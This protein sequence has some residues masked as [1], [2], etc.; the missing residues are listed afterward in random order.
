M[1]RMKWFMV[2]E[3]GVVGMLTT[4]LVISHYSSVPGPGQYVGCIFRPKD[5]KVA[6][7]GINIEATMWPCEE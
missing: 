2:V 6:G 1:T 4:L 5:Q 3:V 7:G